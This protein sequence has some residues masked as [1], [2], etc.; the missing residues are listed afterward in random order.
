V[1][2]FVDSQGVNA[3]GGLLIQVLPK[4]ARDEELISLLESRLAG[5]AGFTPLVRSGKT[6]PE[7][8]EDLLGDLGLNILPQNQL[9]QFSCHCSGDRVIGALKILGTDELR[10]M[11]EKDNGAEVT[12]EFCNEVYQIPRTE[13]EQLVDDLIAEKS[14]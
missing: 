10:D 3:A 4:A 1:G 5:L 11:I 14:S 6:L 13:L 2:V 8:F 9:V 7:I 12:C